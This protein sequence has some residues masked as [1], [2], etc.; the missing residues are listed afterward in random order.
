MENSLF[1][2]FCNH[3][4]QEKCT[5]TQNDLQS[6]KKEEIVAA[7]R[8]GNRDAHYDLGVLY[9]SRKEYRKAAESYRKAADIG[10]HLKC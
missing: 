5:R 6:L 9:E 10:K 8:Q 1:L 3:N 2:L 7:K 4:L